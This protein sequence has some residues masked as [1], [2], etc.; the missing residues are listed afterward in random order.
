MISSC[1]FCK[2]AV[3]T[4]ARESSEDFC[5]GVRICVSEKRDANLQYILSLL[6]LLILVQRKVENLFSWIGE[7]QTWFRFYCSTKYL[8]NEGVFKCICEMYGIVSALYSKISHTN[9]AHAW[10]VILTWKRFGLEHLQKRK[11]R[12]ST[13]PLVLFLTKCPLPGVVDYAL[14]LL[15]HLLWLIRI[16]YRI[17]PLEQVWIYGII[18]QQFTES[19]VSRELSF[20]IHKM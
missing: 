19:W 5:S 10:F 2:I 9:H 11:T 12:R 16:R 17:H 4:L 15:L 3:A 1:E 20:A 14:T 6:T 13:D 8:F 18:K 7:S